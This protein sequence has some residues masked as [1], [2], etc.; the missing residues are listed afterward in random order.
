MGGNPQKLRPWDLSVDPENEPPLRP[1]AETEELAAKC[2]EVFRR[3]D[4]ELGG[5]FGLMRSSG[6]LD[7]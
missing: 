3:L 5:Q 6:W 4:P 7:L 1:F 2:E